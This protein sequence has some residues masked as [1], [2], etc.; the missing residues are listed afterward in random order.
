[1]TVELVIVPAVPQ[2][3]ASLRER[4]PALWPEGDALV[5]RSLEFT[6]WL[7]AREAVVIVTAHG[8][9]DGGF[10]ALVRAACAAVSAQGGDLP[11]ERMPGA[12]PP[13][14]LRWLMGRQ[15]T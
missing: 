11:W 10:W 15:R 2:P 7:R 3:G 6:A 1:M 13:P 5:Y 12:P 4:L 8:R 9:L 14:A